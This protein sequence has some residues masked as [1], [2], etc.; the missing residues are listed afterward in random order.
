MEESYAKRGYLLED[1]R[2]FHL[3]DDRGT[4]MDAHYHEFHKLTYIIS[5]GG[6]YVVEGRRYLV[7]P[8]DIILVGSRCVH[9]PEFAPGDL[10]E[11]IVL[12]ISPQLMKD[13]SAEDY[14]LNEVFSGKR[15]HV[16]RPGSEFRRSFLSLMLR[17]ES[18]LAGSAPGRVILSKCILLR[19]LVELGR[20]MDKNGTDLPV[21]VAAKDG[22]VL[23]IL[24]YL[25]EN[26][27]ADISIDDLAGM[28]YISKYHMMR[29][30]REEAGISIHTYLS[31]KRLMLARDLM[32]AGA[33]ATDACFG[34]GFRSYSAFSRAYSKLFG[35]TPTGRG[36][37]GSVLP[38]NMNM[39]E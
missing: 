3:K 22:K 28:F 39:I 37:T 9:K 8:G 36:M 24:R 2:L 5:G 18:E 34:C 29:R 26:L 27:T 7:Q 31:D 11:R 38:D 32:R 23:E 35:S 1:F 4:E 15:G 10:Y 19:A 33:S 21:P 30:F 12:Y 14:D 13:S 20:E 17:L 16:L 25:D 6:G